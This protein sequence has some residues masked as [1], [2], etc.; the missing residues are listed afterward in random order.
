ML[1]KD[2][3]SQRLSYDETTGIFVWLR[4]AAQPHEN[5]AKVATWNT[6]YAGKVA[7]VKTHGYVR[8]SVNDTKYYAHRLAWLIHYGEWPSGIIDHIDCNGQNNSIA[9]LRDVT[10]VE[11]GRNLRAPR[12][13]RSGIPGVYQMASGKFRSQRKVGSKV[14]HLG[15][16]GSAEE[17][18]AAFIAALD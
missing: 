4:R 2:E 14:V 1:T 18:R 3:A 11:N 13:S 5:A 8:I 6:M 7:G 15:V 16:F 12:K 9:N 17:A 10:K